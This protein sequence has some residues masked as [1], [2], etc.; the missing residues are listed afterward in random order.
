MSWGK[1]SWIAVNAVLARWTLFFTMARSDDSFGFITT[2]TTDYLVKSL[3]VVCLYDDILYYVKSQWDLHKSLICM[4]ARFMQ[5]NVE[6]FFY[7]TIYCFVPGMFELCSVNIFKCKG[8][9]FFFK[10]ILIA[11][12]SHLRVCAVKNR[13]TKCCH[14]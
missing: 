10:C 14:Y 1:Y 13:V 4:P 2:K 12:R 6:F 5:C 11:L 8:V 7:L 3:N 9:N